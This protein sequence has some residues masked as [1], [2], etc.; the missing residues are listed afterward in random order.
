LKEKT[1]DELKGIKGIGEKTAEK[2]SLIVKN[3]GK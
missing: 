1:L 2:I 3:Y